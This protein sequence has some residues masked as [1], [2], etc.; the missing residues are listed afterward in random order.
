METIPK[1]YKAMLDT[2][3]YTE[4]TLGVS[5]NGYDLL[6]NFFTINGWSDNA[7][8]GHQGKNWSVPIGNDFTTAAGRY[9]FLASSWY[10]MSQR[11]KDILKLPKLDTP[12]TYKKVNYNYNAP[13]NKVNQ[14][15]LA[16]KYLKLKKITEELLVEAEKSVNNFSTMIEKTKLDCTWTSLAR[17]LSSSAKPC[18]KQ[19]KPGE[20]KNKQICT[21][22][23]CSSGAEEIWTVYKIALSKY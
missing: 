12:I 6:F 15:Y 13:F 3:A 16:Y 4:G 2:L 7:E 5:N 1:H 21:P 11:E 23:V 14:D 10:D 20:T 18:E 17:S 9:Q 19:A 8:F 22:K